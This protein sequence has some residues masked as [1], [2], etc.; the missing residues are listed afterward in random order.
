MID[1]K[2]KCILLLALIPII[3][4]FGWLNC[5]GIN[6]PLFDDHAFKEF[7]L[8][9]N[10]TDSIL[11]KLQLLFSQHNEH[12]IA[13]TR[14]VILT[15]YGLTGQLNYLNMMWAGNLAMFGILLV[16]YKA[17]FLEKPPLNRYLLYA[18]IPLSLVLFT[19]QHHENTFWGMAS[20]QN[21]GVVFWSLFCFYLLVRQRFMVAMM[22]GFVAT[23]SSG[24]GFLVLAIAAV[25]FLLQKQ[26][27]RLIQWIVFS[28]LLSVVY[29]YGYT[30]PPG[31]P[32]E[33]SWGQGFMVVKG[34]LVLVGGAFD[35]SFQSAEKERLWVSTLAGI[36]IFLPL[37]WLLVREL[38]RGFTNKKWDEWQLFWVGTSLFVLGTLG[39]TVITRLGFGESLLLTSR[40]KIYSVLLVMLVFVALVRQINRPKFVIVA[41]SL[42]CF[43]YAVYVYFQQHSEVVFHR[44]YLIASQFNSRNEP[45]N[46][47][48]AYQ[49]PP[50]PFDNQWEQKPMMTSLID[51]MY[52]VNQECVVLNQNLEIGSG[53]NDATFVLVTSDTDQVMFPTRQ[54]RNLGK[55][56]LLQTFRYYRT[57]FICAFSE[58]EIPNG[59]Y[60]LSIVQC[61]DGKT[62]VTPTGRS[63]EVQVKD[64]KELLKNW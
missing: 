26:Y 20:I 10:K 5:Y 16:F 33:A 29:F 9:W 48:V 55:K 58:K 31:N 3:I 40:Y 64:R 18:I 23:F 6:I 14:F 62:T 27:R 2:K 36:I 56:N 49:K 60:S 1:Y 24:N 17:I 35:V 7:L 30:K 34:F 4:Y 38:I 52:K 22:V 8:Q 32:A 45:V 41:L 15:I 44:N 11:Q 28:V 63:I 46:K 47:L 39:I 42:L 43:V 59:S 25:L 54:N 57:G 37:F 53:L 51:T 50:L 61:N 13:Y 21:F 19:L 12:R